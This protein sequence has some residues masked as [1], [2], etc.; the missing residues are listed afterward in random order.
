MGAV[1]VYFLWAPNWC[2]R[3]SQAADEGVA[4]AIPVR[5]ARGGQL[6][7]DGGDT[8]CVATSLYA[9]T[10]GGNLV[11]CRANSTRRSTRRKGLKK[12]KQVRSAQSLLADCFNRLIDD[13][14]KRR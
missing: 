9:A 8:A 12:S 11:E 2:E 7:G 13:M 6:S 14:R 3:V 4:E 10:S 5:S 1:F